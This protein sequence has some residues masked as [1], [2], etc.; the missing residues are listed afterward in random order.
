MVPPEVRRGSEKVMLTV[1]RVLQAE[2]ADA[3][4]LGW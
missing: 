4:A 3:K 1:G 2:S